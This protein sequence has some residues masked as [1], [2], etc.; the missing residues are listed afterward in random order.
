MTKISTLGPHGSDSC[1]AAL[2][3]DENAEVLLFNH[4]DDVLSCVEHGESDYALIPVYN[5]REGEIKE[6]FRIMAEL[7]QNFWVDNIVMPIHLSLGGANQQISPDEIKFIYGRSSVLNQCD[8][9][10]SRN[11]PHATR[12]SIHD[13]SEAV[14]EITSKKNNIGVLIDTEEVIALHNLALIDRELAAHN[15]TR[16]ALIGSTS[17][18]QTGYDATSIITKPLA[19][20]VGLLVDTLNEFTKRGINIVDLR[21]KNDIETQ[22]LQIYLEIEGHRTDP[23]LA[24]ALEDIET[25][26]I[27][28]PRCLRIL[29]SFPRVDMRVKKIS[30]FGFIGSG[31][32]SRW[33]SE[34]LQSE[35]YKTLMTGRTSK[36]RPEQ[37]IGEADVVI[38]CVPISATTETIEKYGGQLHDGQALVILAGESEKP[39]ERALQI[40]SEGVEVMLVHNLW[41]PQV[42][43]MKDKNVAV[44]KT[45]RS[46][47]LCNEFE[48]FLYK[49]GA[50]IYQDSAEKH[51]LMMGVSQKLPTIISVAMAMTLSQHDIG[52]DDIDSHSTLTSLYGIL[53]MARVHNQNPRTYAEI[54]ATSGDSSKI[55]DSFIDNLTT[56]SLLAAQRSITQLE[57]IIEV[58]RDKIPADFIRTKMN[59]AQAVDAVLSDIGFK[60][61]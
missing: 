59:Q 33:F 15:R 39:L 49:Y 42:P 56:V 43:T 26:V 37:M 29:G 35:G 51:D 47:S 45:R 12:V 40:T 19:D 1:Q 3:Y 14:E 2:R 60:G 25:K 27:Q 11:M 32:M 7:D 28:E 5:T 23:M 8:D 4:I 50:E 61:E 44:V 17:R 30:T 20:R 31:E 18:P 38:V 24:E 41:G 48:A 10:I 6:Y 36:L 9:Y 13:V 34:Q 22:K 53:A 52:F 57:D 21:S 55:V 58:N 54:M 46:G 16:F